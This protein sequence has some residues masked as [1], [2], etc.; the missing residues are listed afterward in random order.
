MKV[1]HLTTSGSL[2]GASRSAARLHLGLREIGVRS[3]LLVQ[4][5]GT[6]IE[7]A[8]ELRAPRGLPA[9]LW[10][11]LGAHCYGDRTTVSNTFFSAPIPGAE[12]SDVRAIRDADVIHLHW[13]AHFLTPKS[14]A[15]LARMDRPIVWT[16]HDQRPFTG[17]C[18][19]SAGCRGYVADCGPCPQLQDDSCRLP[20]RVLAAQRLALPPG[21]AVVVAPS[22]WLADC[23]RQS[24]LFAGSRVEVIPYGVDTSAFTP[25]D[26][27]AARAELGLPASGFQ[28]LFG[29]DHGMELR[30][31]AAELAAALREFAR[32]PG[33]K[34]ASHLVCFGRPSPLMADVGLPLHE[35]GY[36][37]GDA[38]LRRAYSAADAFVLPSLEDNLPNTMLEAL[39]CGTPVVAFEIGGVPDVVADARNGR[40]VAPGDLAAFGAA[41]HD[42]LR[43]S[44]KCRAMGQE[45]A[46]IIREGFQLSHQAERYRQLYASLT[47]PEPATLNR[48][49][50]PDEAALLRHFIAGFIRRVPALMRRIPKRFS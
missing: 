31:G 5:G 16:L 22:R 43:D 36:L 2:G 37:R 42:F 30:K 40:V 33:A 10:G 14:L 21:R 9:R 8:E 50:N 39:A 27:A 13:V 20:S 4:E 17:G 25:Q 34:E 26:R 15:A 45:G 19:F 11:F 6:G 32:L 24:A 44:A 23:A 38:A 49:G 29:A 47:V 12:L 3:T 1:V 46:R 35:L 28:I 48:V 18:H 7:A 41:L